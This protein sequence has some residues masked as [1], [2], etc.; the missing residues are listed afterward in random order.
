M[1]G[2]MFSHFLR[3]SV[4]QLNDP[5][6]TCTISVPSEYDAVVRFVATKVINQSKKKYES[7]LKKKLQR[8]QFPISW[9]AFDG[10]HA[11]AFAAALEH[12]M[13]KLIGSAQKIKEFENEFCVKVEETKRN[14][15]ETNETALRIFHENLAR[16]YWEMFVVVGLQNGN[17]FVGITVF[18]IF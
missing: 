17:F 15:R 12:L 11:D 3:V 6:N 1:D 4:A 8:N 10:M 2:M 14:Y 18:C 16:R 9:E 5:A 7:S 13:T